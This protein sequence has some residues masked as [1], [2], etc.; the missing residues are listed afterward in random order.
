MNDN[1]REDWVELISVIAHDLRTPISAMRGNIELV[2]ML[3][4]LNDKQKLHTGRVLAGLQHMEMLINMLLDMAWLEDDR[5]LELVQC[6]PGMLANQAVEL[7]D[8]MAL[9][10]DIRIEVVESPTSGQLVCDQTR[11]LQVLVNLLSNAIKYNREGGQI[12][13]RVDGDDERVQF[14]V[15]DTGIGIPAE[16]FKHIFER[17]YRVTRPD[18]R[19]ITGSGLGLSIVRGIIEK[20]NGEIRAASKPGEGTLFT[21]ILPRSLPNETPGQTE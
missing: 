18:G 3:G 19:S 16:D 12:W 10:R 21:L 14:E 6:T 8:A 1:Q 4:S 5:P 17:F 20:H 7:L 2:E 13:I 11:M 15:E 9:V